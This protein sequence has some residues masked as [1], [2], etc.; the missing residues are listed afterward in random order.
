[1]RQQKLYIA[2]AGVLLLCAGCK[3]DD[4]ADGTTPLK[5]AVYVDAATTTP[6]TNVTFKKTVSE[7]DRQIK[8]VFISPVQA[9]T[10]VSIK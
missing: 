10:E 2:L 3:S 1:M 8:A 6:E 4:Y 5:N 7:L 9:S